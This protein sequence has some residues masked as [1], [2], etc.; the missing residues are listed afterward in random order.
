MLSRLS[1]LS[2][3]SQA[4]V[5]G[6][7][8]LAVFSLLLPIS[9]L[10]IVVPIV[11]QF[12]VNFDSRALKHWLRYKYHHHRVSG[13]TLI[14]L[15]IVLVVIGLVVGGIFVG[16]D[17]I[18]AAGERAQITQIEKFQSAVAAFYEKYRFLPGDISS[19]DATKFGFIARGPN[20][21]EGDGNGILQAWEGAYAT[22]NGMQGETSVFWVDLSTARMI[23]GTFNTATMTTAFCCAT[24]TTTPSLNA[25]FPQAKIGNSN[26]VY[27]YS[28]NSANYFCLSG[29]FTLGSAPLAGVLSL[30]VRQAYDIDQKI[31]D[32]LPQSGNVTA[33]YGL[34]ASGH[35]VPGYSWA[36][37][38]ANYGNT[39]FTTTTPGSATTCFDNSSDP[40]GSPGISGATQHYS[41]EMSNGANVNCALSFK[42]QTGD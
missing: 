19:P 33:V 4:S 41:V 1:P 30:T 23:E 28:A 40:S 7:V 10:F 9:T 35:Y 6:I 5:V 17:M 13:F 25:F 27:I 14:E 21:G 29:V 39:P 3:H 2:R 37:Y 42:F 24:Q 38:A 16:Q 32:G 11:I 18:R 34:A 15:S 36:G 31:D 8:L 12:L 26:Y 20:P 22:T